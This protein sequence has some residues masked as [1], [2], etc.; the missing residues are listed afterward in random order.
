MK[1]IAAALILAAG[2]V[3]A[4]DVPSGQ[5]VELQEVLIDDLGGEIWLRF[6]FVAPQINRDNGTVS[7]VEAGDD[8]AHLCDA[9]ALPYLEHHAL[10]GDVIAVS[11][12][13]RPTEFGVADP[14]STQIFEAFR[15][16]G[17]TCEWDGL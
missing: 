7:P 16:V 13:D 8:M 12:S 10:T 1:A 17:D 11:L 3:L 2:P 14:D 9:V 6:R 4:I 15:I 5:P